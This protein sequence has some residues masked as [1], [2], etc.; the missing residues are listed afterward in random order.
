MQN[1]EELFKS[2]KNMKFR[3]QSLASFVQNDFSLMLEDGTTNKDEIKQAI[4]DMDEGFDN[5]ITELNNLREK[6]RV[7]MK[8]YCA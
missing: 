8:H 3:M 4:K 5:T 6:S 2:I 7:I 1:Q